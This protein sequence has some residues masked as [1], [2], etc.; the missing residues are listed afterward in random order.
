MTVTEIMST[1]LHTLDSDKSM[2]DARALM[3]SENIRHVPILENGIVVGIVSQRDLLKAEISSLLSVKTETRKLMEQEVRITDMC[4][5]KL[6]TVSPK[7]SLLEAARYIQK[8]K[9]GC[10]PVVEGDELLGIV[11][12]SDFVNVAINLLEIASAED[13]AG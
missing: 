7:S 11:T 9:L 13:T 8:H 2:Y 4:T 6:V 12:D 3:M 1:N 5:D 10:L